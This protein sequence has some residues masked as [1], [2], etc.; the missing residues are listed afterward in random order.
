TDETAIDCL[1]GMNFDCVALQPAA[2]KLSLADLTTALPTETLVSPLPLL[3]YGAVE[4]PGD[5]SAWQY[6]QDYFLVHYAEELPQAFDTMVLALHTR[7]S[8][9]PE[10][11]R[12]LLEQLREIELP[13]RDRKVLS[14]MTTCAIF[15]RWQRWW[16]S[17]A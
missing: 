4:T 1:R 16:K 3:L 10:P 6:A 9:V 15:L 12:Q 7:F 14:S 13:L 11:Q 8:Q 2:S 5:L 17:T